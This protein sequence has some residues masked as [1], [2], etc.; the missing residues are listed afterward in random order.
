MSTNNACQLA[1]WADVHSVN[2]LKQ[3]AVNCIG[4]N[5]RSLV[6]SQVTNETNEVS[7]I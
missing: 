4:E 1:T 5:M 2:A 3:K 6:S 7:T